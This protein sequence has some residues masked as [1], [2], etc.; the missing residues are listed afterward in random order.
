MEHSALSE[1]QPT[2][3]TRGRY[4]R[5]TNRIHYQKQTAD[6]FCRPAFDNKNQTSD[7]TMTGTRWIVL[8]IIIVASSVSYML[9]INVSI[10]GDAMIRD[11]GMNAYQLGIVLS[12]FAAGYTIFQFPGGII[13]DKFGPRLTI[14]TIA[15]A[16]T[17]L[18]VVTAVIPGTE[19]WS[20]GLIVAAL[21]ATRF[22]V[23]LSHGPFFPVTIGG[24]IARWFPVKQWGIANGLIVAGLTLGGA[25]AGP[26]I[27]WLMES[28]GWRGAMLL[29]APTGLIIA[30]IYFRYVTDN[31]ADHARMTAT[32]LELINSDRP[33][34]EEG[35]E[36][37][38][39]KAA[40]K[41]RNVLLL[42]ISYFCMNYV[43]YLFFNWFF[44][45]LVNVKQFS[46][47]DAALFV[48]AQ[49]ILGAAGGLV[50]GFTCDGLVRR[51]GIS[52][53]P[54]ILA[55]TGLILS[56]LFLYVGA[57]SDSTVIAVVMLCAAFGCTQI[58]DTPYWV[59]IMSMS[60]RHAPVATGILN[61]GGNVPGVIGAMSVPFL[62]DVL[63]WP[64]AMASGSV[65]A[66]VGALLWL[67]VKADKPVGEAT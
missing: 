41:N 51:F 53:G 64:V 34:G 62:A 67:F 13:G 14:T 46:A 26:I 9:R 59:A 10:L 66:V 38:A 15:V 16:W 57:T 65:F 2:P 58:T 4:R 29:T 31:P 21:V 19:F 35:S 5:S 61:T 43:F 20:V 25:A 50:G 8:A 17:L 11:L 56:A 3:S 49:W 39:W 32:E 1:G 36:K 28:Y 7:A 30:F 23:G 27:V 47:A 44:F 42:T 45:Y 55:M 40:L 6:N 33:R 12:A 63:G 60:G 37:G 54:R 24:T 48:T 52:R 18:T 22:L